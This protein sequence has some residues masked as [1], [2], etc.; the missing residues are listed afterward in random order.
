MENYFFMYLALAVAIICTI[1]SP[2]E[3]I[4]TEVRLK[5]T[6]EDLVK[7]VS[8]LEKA[9]SE[10]ESEPA[11]D[12]RPSAEN[13]IRQHVWGGRQSIDAFMQHPERNRSTHS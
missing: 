6:I 7:R 13:E 12:S 1:I 8:R 9:E 11:S 3:T 2:G 4:K 10:P 5:K